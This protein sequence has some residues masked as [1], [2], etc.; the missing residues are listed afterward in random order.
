[1]SIPQLKAFRRLVRTAEH[2][3][4]GHGKADTD[5]SNLKTKPQKLQDDILVFDFA[6][7]STLM[8]KDGE[9]WIRL[10]DVMYFMTDKQLDFVLSR[11]VGLMALAHKSVGGTYALYDNFINAA[12]S[13]AK[14]ALREVKK[15]MLAMITREG[16]VK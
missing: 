3:D 7:I 11:G 15:R 2:M 9:L 12:P 1:M 14:P 16:G 10:D 6:G 13:K 8:W 5:M 4:N